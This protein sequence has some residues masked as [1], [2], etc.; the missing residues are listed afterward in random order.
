MGFVKNI[1][2]KFSL[3]GKPYRFV[4]ANVYELANLDSEITK[5][6]IELS[7]EAGFIALR[8]WLFEN[9]P[10]DE[11]IKKLN[12]IC[13]AV[14]P[15]GIKLIVSLAD[16]WGYLQNYRIDERW[17][18]AG[19]RFAYTKY[20]TEITKECSDRDEIMIWELIN[21]PETDK[22]SV[23]YD[24]AKAASEEIKNVNANHMVS[25]G[26]VG[27]IGDKFGSNFSIFR[28]G[29]FRKLYSLESLDAISLHD[30]SYDASVFERL[31]ILYRFRGELKKAERYSAI[32]DKIE[33]PFA[34]IDK[35][36][37]K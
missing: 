31:D 34:V 16:K 1:D 24:F 18:K 10:V 20:V 32:G 37:N 26:T 30:Y 5:Q 25:V 29:N 14:N 27:G 6:I 21:E 35:R 11:Q 22:F 8:F 28:K 33:K 2:G 13:D 36:N 19:F 23:F 15:Y 7:A 12:E 3:D 17:Y 4:G 9:K